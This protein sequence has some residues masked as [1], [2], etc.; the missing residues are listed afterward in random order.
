M[1][2]DYLELNGFK[3]VTA[4]DGIEGLAQ[5]QLAYPDLNL[6][7]IQM[8]RM[9][10]FETTKKLR[11]ELEF[12]HTPI[13]ALTA[14]AM[15]NDRE[16]CL[17]AGM[18]EYIAKPVH[19]RALVKFIEDLLGGE[20]DFIGEAPGM[21]LGLSTVSAIVWGAGGAFRIMNREGGP[22]MIV[23]FLIPEVNTDDLS[24]AFTVDLN[25]RI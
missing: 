7:D 10:G 20:Q 25:D 14:F 1:I 18:D 24:M 9:D 3:I 21:G 23:E 12:M 15:P 5:A 16:R 19:L 2:S 13:I 17:A 6:M 8:P 4:Q 11:S 22:G